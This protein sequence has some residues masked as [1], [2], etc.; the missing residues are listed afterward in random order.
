VTTLSICI[1]THERPGMLYRAL[2][3]VIWNAPPEVARTVQIVVSDNSVSD[4]SEAL[5]CQLLKEWGGLTH[6]QRNRPGVGMVGN[7]NRCIEAA[8]G[9]WVLILHDDDYL[10]LGA[11]SCLLRGIARA[12]ASDRTLLFGVRVVDDRGR[13]IRPQRPMRER[14]LSPAQALGRLL[15]RSSYIRFP[16]MVVHRSAYAEAGPFE[17]RMQGATDLQMWLRLIA[18]HGLRTVPDTTAAYVVHADAATESTFTPEQVRLLMSLFD[19]AR[20]L[21]V[22]PESAL[23]RAQCQWFHQFIL[24]SAF[25]RLRAGDRA[26]AREMLRLFDLPEV[27][28]LGTSPVWLPLRR[29]FTL[30]AGSDRTTSDPRSRA[31]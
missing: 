30:L 5:A 17:A 20:D 1:P 28:A 10:L 19:E 6:Y 21:A 18:R 23:S 29:T 3:S 16:G 31:G 14:S 2:T 11:V 12:S 15:A 7:F 8:A 13:L 25:R 26:A 24:A 27:R 9:D 4:A 22:L